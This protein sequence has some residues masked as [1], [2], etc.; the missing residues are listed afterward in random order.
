MKNHV[1]FLGGGEKS[2][3]CVH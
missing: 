3:T 1:I 2:D